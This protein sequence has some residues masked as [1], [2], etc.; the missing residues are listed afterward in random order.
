MRSTIRAAV[1]AALVLALAAACS[2]PSPAGHSARVPGAHQD[3]ASADPGTPAGAVPRSG[4]PK[5]ASPDAP[6]L[7]ARLVTPTDIDLSWRAG[8]SGAAGHVLE[9]ATEEAGPYT[10]LEYLPS[11]TTT[12]RHPDLI[13]RTTFFYR[14]R[15]FQG[16]ASTPVDVSLPP[17]G[18]TK[19]DEEAGHDWLPPRTVP[20]RSAA[21]RSVRERRAAP[22]GL[23]AEI[24]HANGI[25][26][27][28]TDRTS[29][30]SG[31]LL[32]ARPR[33]ASAFAPIVVLDPGVN[34]TGL[35]TL[36]TEKHASYRIR[37]F[38]TGADSNV[39]R[40]TTGESTDDPE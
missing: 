31:F 40:L 2:A 38:V 8:A 32:E 37:A 18:P 21:G 36:P 25:L 26:F 19:A 27:T 13:P 14:L 7:R 16:P 20:G 1:P 22:S 9:F 11:G 3:G 24:K 17:G 4:S 34:S 39:V 10:V 15:A 6:T 35:I 12:Y 28:W 30:E 23:K 29:D 33:G 5:S